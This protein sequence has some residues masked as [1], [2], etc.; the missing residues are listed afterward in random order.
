MPKQRKM[1][2]MDEPAG[3]SNAGEEIFYVEKILDKK[4]EH[5]KAKYL[6]RWRGYDER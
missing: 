1:K 4:I 2:K 3:D 6:I 5:G